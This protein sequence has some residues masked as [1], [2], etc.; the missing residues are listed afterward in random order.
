MPRTA[1]APTAGPCAAARARASGEV[2]QRVLPGFDNS[3]D[4]NRLL[5]GF[6]LFRNVGDLD[7]FDL[8]LV[9]LN[10]VGLNRGDVGNLG[11]R[12]ERLC[13][14][15]CRDLL[16]FSRGDNLLGLLADH[17][18]VGR[19]AAIA[20]A[21][22]RCVRTALTVGEDCGAAAGVV[23]SPPSPSPANAASASACANS[24]SDWISTFQP[25][26]RAARRAFRPSLPIASASWSSVDNGGLLGLVVDVDLTHPCGRERL[27][28]EPGRL[29]SHGMM[30][31]FSPRSSDT[32][33]RTREPLGPTQA[34]TGS[35]P[36]AE[37]RRDLRAVAGLTSNAADHDEAIRD[38]GHLELEERLDQLRVATRQDHLRALRPRA[39][40]GDDGLDREPCS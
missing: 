38:L 18:L 25:V 27:R 9:D 39:D 29:R 4:R 3:L 12:L 15:G 30:S 28:D 22:E 16:D 35:T 6:R 33:M 20:C 1:E 11:N 34:P 23:P 19:N 37:T 17:R 32:T 31:I 21:R 36:W 40:F 2:T 14:G 7:L 5:D 10:L 24:S 8:N 26:R 13:L